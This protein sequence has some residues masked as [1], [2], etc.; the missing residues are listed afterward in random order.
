MSNSTAVPGGTPRRAFRARAVGAFGLLLTSVIA[1]SVATSTDVRATVRGTQT[2]VAA[3]LDDFFVPG[4]QPGTLTQPVFSSDACSGCHGNYDPVAEP[5]TQWAASMMGQ[6]G[7]DPIFYAA[8][9]VANQDVDFGG[10]LCLRCHAPGAWL[11]GRS[12]PTDGSALDPLLGDLDGVTCHMCHRMVDPVP[13]AAN[14][15]E[16]TAILANLTVPALQEPHSASFV[17]DPD[18]N[19]RGP[20]DLGMFFYHEW[21]ESPFHR[22]SRMCATCHDVSNPLLQLQADGSYQLNAYD[23]PSP[24]ADKNEMFPVER[25][26][27][28]WATSVF[29]QDDI[30]MGGR[31]GGNDPEVATCQDCHMPKT[32]GNGCLPALGSPTRNDLARHTFSGVNNWVLRAIRSQFPDTVTGLTQQSVDDAITRNETMLQSAADLEAIVDQG[33]LRVRVTNQT[34]HKLP[35]GYGEGRRIWIDVRYFDAADALVDVRGGYDSVNAVLDTATTEV[36]EIEH[37][38]DAT[39]SAATGVPAGK[40][41]HFLLN[42]ETLKD[43]RIPARGFRRDVYEAIGAEVVAAPYVDAQYWLERRFDVPAGA[44]RAEVRLYHQTT[45]KEYIEFLRDE[46]TSDARGT[47]AYQLWN[48]FGK[49]AP[50][51]MNSIDVDLANSGELAPR[52]L[53]LGKVRPDGSRAEISFS[54]SPS[55]TGG[56]GV[57]EIRGGNPNQLMVLFS[58]S[59]MGSNDN[60][61]GVYNVGPGTGRL[62]FVTLDANG[63]ADFPVTFSPSQANGAAVFQAFFREPLD[64]FAFAMTGGIRIEVL[65]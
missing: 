31:F 23:T 54:G 42:N 41:F 2:Q 20:Y 7:R 55:V 63:D 56:G 59:S 25:T 12:T 4:T 46:N 30:D 22:E 21:R 33:D 58:S 15:A 26:Y 52:L 13:D 32:S 28:E 64:P 6:A 5:F 34:G 27:S 8:L 65:P 3:T 1:G 37:G 60:F 9:A 39:M 36:I 11:E 49:S 40:S 50:V 57:V 29:A 24:A 53:D 45:S 51:E 62:G 44:V 10:E 16:D 61:G 43:N 17:I 47:E 35:T 38:L 48:M 14:P 19:R 18:D